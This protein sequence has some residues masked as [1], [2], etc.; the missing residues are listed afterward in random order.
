VGYE[1]ISKLYSLSQKENLDL[2]DCLVRL[3]G[4]EIDLPTTNSYIDKNFIVE[5][6]INSPVEVSKL[7]VCAT[8]EIMKDISKW[9]L[10][11]GF[12]KGRIHFV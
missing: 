9:C 12:P 11:L 6:I 5:H 8:N 4:A 3:K 2:F 10:E 7:I 1:F